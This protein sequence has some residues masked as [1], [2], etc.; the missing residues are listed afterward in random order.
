MKVG[1]QKGRS[2]YGRGAKKATKGRIRE[3]SSIPPPF[4]VSTKELYIILEAWVKDGV[5]VLPKCKC[6]P[7]KEEKRGMVF[8]RYH[9]RSDHYT[10]DC[11][12]SRK[13]FHEKV[14]KS[15]FVMKNGKRMDIRMH[16]PKV[17]MT[18]FMGCEDPMGEEAENMVSSSS[19]PSPLQDE[20]MSLRI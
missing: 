1:E 8:C 4:S 9:R 11:F 14:P 5:V 7:T 3:R 19:A 18:F 10:M 12:A 6:E 20:E 15:D 17:A 16:R 2:S 13:S